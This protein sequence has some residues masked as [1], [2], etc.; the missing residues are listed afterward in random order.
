MVIGIGGIK[1][2]LFIPLDCP[3]LAHDVSVPVS[4]TS[5]LFCTQIGGSQF[6][7]ENYEQF[8]F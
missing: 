1:R 5:G 8:A 4:T 2:H 7:F 6:L 3:G